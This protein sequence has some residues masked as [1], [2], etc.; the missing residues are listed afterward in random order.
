MV[1]H[2]TLLY[3]PVTQNIFDGKKFD[4]Y[5]KAMDLINMSV[6]R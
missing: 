1:L 2:C 5:E 4:E 6:K 3:Y